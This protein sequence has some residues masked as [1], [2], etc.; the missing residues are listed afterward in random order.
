MIHVPLGLPGFNRRQYS[1]TN[2][3]M[4]ICSIEQSKY[5]SPRCARIL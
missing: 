5:H 2:R 3:K 1:V 4:W